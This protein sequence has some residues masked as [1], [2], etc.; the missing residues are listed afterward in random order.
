MSKARAAS[1]DGVVRALGKRNRPGAQFNN[2][3]G[4]PAPNHE[5]EHVGAS[6]QHGDDAVG[7]HD[8]DFSNF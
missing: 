8:D 7:S 3:A 2:G 5:P 4:S 1:E 6:Q